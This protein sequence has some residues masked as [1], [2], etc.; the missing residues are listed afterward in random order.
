MRH[1]QWRICLI[2]AE[3]TEVQILHFFKK[4]L[5]FLLVF[6]LLFA[7]SACE[8]DDGAAYLVL[9][10]VGEKHYGSV[11]RLGDKA[12]AQ[13]NAALQDLAAAGE[14][15]R[16]CQAW[17]SRDLITLESEGG[18]LA[19]LEEAPAPRTLIVGVENDFDR[20]SY[21][22]ENGDYVGMSVDIAKAVG[23]LL[24]WEIQIQPINA[25]DMATQ[26]SS[27]N[28]DCALGFGIETVDTGKF[29][30]GACYM[31]S[32]IVIAA[33]SGGEV[34]KLKHLKGLKIGAVKDDSI[35]AAVEA[36][37]DAMKYAESVTPY[38]SPLRCR[39]ALEN[40]WC[41]AIA[42]DEVM[43]GQYS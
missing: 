43:L 36:S 30:A 41:A 29:T 17:L 18:N 22:D 5:A 3:K 10:T 31:K 26:L 9:E 33:P 24:G 1:I 38:L 28:I 25:G 6:A 32:A 20:L 39:T 27:G 37:G 16:I 14:L 11:F 19:A 34:K 4:Y 12:A 35:L 15:S 40:G 2:F 13:V 42:M 23:G 7:L 8:Q 21:P